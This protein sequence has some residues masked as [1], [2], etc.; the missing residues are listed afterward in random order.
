M[1]IVGLTGSIGMGKST[2]GGFLSK[3]GARVYDADAAVHRLFEVGGAAVEPIRRRFP[4]AISEG[5]VD[6]TILGRIVFGDP[7]GL[8]DLEAI[9]HPMVR[10]AQRDFLSRASLDRRRLVVLDIPLLFETGGDRNCDATILV[11]A[12]PVAQR[13]R[14]LSRPDMT[15]QKLKS[16]LARQMP[17]WIKRQRADFVVH[18][19]FDMAHT[20]S[21]LRGVVSRLRFVKGA[22][23][24]RRYNM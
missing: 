10:R 9:V 16:I 6:R 12:S 21:Q 5:M 11:T 14:V 17:D 8:R 4:D 1:I 3:L 20:F 23:W 7:K 13:R 18:T 2:A 22:H 15:Q 24:P 19:G